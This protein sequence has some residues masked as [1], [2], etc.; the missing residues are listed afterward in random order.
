M[1]TK[2]K[3]RSYMKKSSQNKKT[4]MR[5]SKDPLEQDLSSLIENSELIPATK[6]FDYLPKNKTISIR[7]PEQLLESIK[8]K[9]KSEHK[10]YQKLIREALISLVTEE[11]V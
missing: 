2:R 5:K 11:A 6:L 4:R 8:R 3:L 9:A 1:P 10:D 7:L